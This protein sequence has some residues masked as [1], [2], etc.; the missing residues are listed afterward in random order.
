MYEIFSR[1]LSIIMEHIIEKHRHTWVHCVQAEW[2]VS[3][4][5]FRDSDN[6]GVRDFG[7]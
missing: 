4:G 5:E 6:D 3:F 1:I 2:D 7:V